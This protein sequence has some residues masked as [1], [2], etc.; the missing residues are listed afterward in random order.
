ML[1]VLLVFLLTV[2]V[3]LWNIKEFPLISTKLLKTKFVQP[4][5][6]I[7]VLWIIILPLLISKFY[8][9]VVFCLSFSHYSGYSMT[10]DFVLMKNFLRS[11]NFLSLF[12]IG[13]VMPKKGLK[14]IFSDKKKFLWS[15][16]I[17]FAWYLHRFYGTLIVVLFDTHYDRKKFLDKEEKRHIM[18]F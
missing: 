15:T 2:F 11:W 14:E 13:W 7:A 3:L 12:T 16:K 9:F 18:N 4:R 8:F 10:R 5:L 1:Y 6:N 17:F